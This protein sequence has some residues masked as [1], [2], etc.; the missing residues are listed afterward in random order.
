M[1]SSLPKSLSLGSVEVKSGTIRMHM[2]SKQA[3]ER[4]K[5]RKQTSAQGIMGN[6]NPYKCS[7]LMLAEEM[8]CDLLPKTRELLQIL[9]LQSNATQ[10]LSTFCEKEVVLMSSL[11]FILSFPSL[12]LGPRQ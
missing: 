3:G 2:C 11:E 7:S 10:I 6:C 12:V 1:N 9:L 5:T 4:S 8:A